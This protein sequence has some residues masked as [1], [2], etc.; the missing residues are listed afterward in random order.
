MISLQ[1]ILNLSVGFV[2]SS[3][4]WSGALFV[5]NALDE[6]FVVGGFNGFNYADGV[7]SRLA[8]WGVRLTRNF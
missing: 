7:I 5:T 4:R 3:E 1:A 8:E 6:Q 2:D